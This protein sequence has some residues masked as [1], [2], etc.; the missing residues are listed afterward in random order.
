MDN[1][2]SLDPRKQ[3]LFEARFLG[4]KGITALPSEPLNKDV[5]SFVSASSTPV[6]LT[7]STSCSASNASSLAIMVDSHSPVNSGAS[8]ESSNSRSRDEL[9]VYNK[10]PNEKRARKR[11]ADGIQD[12]NSHSK[13]VKPVADAAGSKKIQDF[14]K[15]GA[16]PR[17]PSA[18]SNVAPA[19]AMPQPVLAASITLSSAPKPVAACMPALPASTPM[20]PAPS[21]KAVA[22]AA[23]TAT[24]SIP[25]QQPSTVPFSVPQPVPS[26]NNSYGS[27]SPVSARSPSPKPKT[28]QL[29]S[30]QATADVKATAVTE[31]SMPAAAATACTTA[32]AAAATASA[33]V[34]SAATTATSNS[35]GT[36]HDDRVPELHKRNDELEQQVASLQKQLEKQKE[37]LVRCQEMNKTL[38]IEKSKI[39]NI[40]LRQKSME[41]RLRLGHFQT[42][43]QG[44][45]FVENWVDGFAFQEIAKK[46]ELINQGKE[47]VEKQRKL[48]AKR[49]P[50]KNTDFV[51]PQ[52]P[53][54]KPL[55]LSEYY[56]QDEVL[57][58]RQ[59]ALKKEDTELQQ[60]LEKLERERNLHIREMKRIQNEDNSRFKDHP[61]LNE[62]Y[63]LLNLLG[64]GGF[65]EVHK[66]FDLK[67]QRYVACK[68]HQLN[69]EWKDEKK[70]N[71][72]KHA[73]REY[74]IHKSL[75]HARIVR[76][77]DVFEIDNNSFCT[78]LEYCDGNDLD[79]YLKQTKTI[80]EREAR[81]I[82]QQTVTALK[83]LNDIKPPVIHYDLKP[84]NILLMSGANTGEIKITDF[85]LSK[86]ME[87]ETYSPESGMDL[88]SQGAGTY[89]YLPPE[90]FVLG[91]NPPK[92][93]SKV[94][95]W[96][97]GVI[98]YQCLYGKKPFGHN[99][100][101][102]AILEENTILNARQVEFPAKPPVSQEAKNFMRRCLQYH[103]E[104]RPDVL[105]L[106][107]DDYLKASA[108]KTKPSSAGGDNSNSG[109]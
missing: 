10:M 73:L 109:F 3:E 71:Y 53:G 85:G 75:D 106:A 81:S 50:P 36:D 31:S 103:K 90:C 58:L 88:T 40:S 4:T 65:S 39:E 54:E 5:R 23:P 49:K 48:L 69:K 7:R 35:T 42:V 14:L 55:S 56:L 96:S 83:H 52:N 37:S 78:V 60:E 66:A 80:P 13:S 12:N 24:S 79:F 44:A 9:G 93:S 26:I 11:K 104:L 100:S 102:A 97:V 76:L 101:Q 92:I 67:E 64:K 59:A 51:K 61:T 45:T 77:F 94:D 107:D 91:K 15:S 8:H 62:R 30:R 108:L 17:R 46:Q 19:V 27:C 68:I 34:A 87:G 89:W 18:T 99:L 22:P 47:D 72:I 105:L 38:L 6:H 43:R 41:N 29:P 16:S 33:T 25:S 1:L 95:V 2:Q 84:G 74:N 21:N 86:I 98:F 20:T 32:V 82:I 28:Q 70:A 57:K 63:L